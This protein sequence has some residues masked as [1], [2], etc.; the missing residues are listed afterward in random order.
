M[1]E[2]NEQVVAVSETI[3]SSSARSS[4]DARRRTVPEGEDEEV[5]RKRPRV[6]R[7]SEESNEIIDVSEMYDDEMQRA[8]YQSKLK[9]DID[10]RRIELHSQY[11]EY[12]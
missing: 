6:D 5:R 8:I 4:S 3:V 7:G 12:V 10:N 11:S 9:S 2:E 1:E